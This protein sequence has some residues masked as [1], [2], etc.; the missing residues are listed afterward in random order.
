MT[1]PDTVF[2][3]DS[4]GSLDSV[5]Y[6][7]HAEGNPEK[8][9]GLKITIAGNSHP[10][11]QKHIEVEFRKLQKQAEEEEQAKAE[12]KVKSAEVKSLDEIRKLNTN[13]I[14]ARVLSANLPIKFRG[15][16]ITLGPVNALEVLSDPKFLWLTNQIRTFIE[17]QEN[18]IPAS[19]QN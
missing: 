1:A 19:A 7:V 3:L 11:Y 9:I 16:P 2:D 8:L 17:N 13:L 6:A 10:E 18:F 4:F 5:E 12:G 14:A 15:N